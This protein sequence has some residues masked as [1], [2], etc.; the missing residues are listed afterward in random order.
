V[1]LPK[2][3]IPLGEPRRRWVVNIKMDFGEIECGTVDWFGVTQVKD[4]WRAVMN[5]WAL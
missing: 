3:K 2:G 5:L 1:G 4:K